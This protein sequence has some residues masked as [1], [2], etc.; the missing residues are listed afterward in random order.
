[1]GRSFIVYQGEDETPEFD[2]TDPDSNV[3]VKFEEMEAGGKAFRGESASNTIPVRDQRGET[4]NELNLPGGLTHVS[5]SRGSRWEW[6]DGPDGSEVRMAAGRIGTKDYTRGV[7]K[8]DRAREV[9]DAV[10]RPQRGAAGHHRRRLGPPRGNRRG[11][12][13]RPAGRLPRR[14]PAHHHGHRRHLRLRGR[15]P[16]PCRRG[17]TTAPTRTPSCR[18]LRRMPTRSSSSPSTTNCGTT[19]TP[20]PRTSQGCE[21]VTGPRR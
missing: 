10:R 13:P 7:Q 9:V 21:S 1:M 16:S 18:R 17:C 15:T 19:S 5:L 3:H 8:A 2:L 6:L 20:R 12:R 14:H 11:P 4:G